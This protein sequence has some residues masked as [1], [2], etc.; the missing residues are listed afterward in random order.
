MATLVMKA[1]EVEAALG[2]MAA[3]L[4]RDPSDGP[5]AVVGIRRGGENLARRLAAHMRT[6]S[7]TE[8]PL[9]MVDITLYRDDG[10]GPHDWPI[11]GPTNIEF[12]MK[13]YTIVLV[14]DVLYTG[15]T[16]RA[17]ID[18]MLDYGRPRA[19]RLAVLVDRGLHELP[20][21]GDAVGLTLETQPT[22]HVDVRVA[23]EPSAEDAVFVGP[24]ADRGGE[25]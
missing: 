17:A 1:A 8:P 13:R 18:A 25:A 12:E 11:I 2:T 22:E 6:H 5:W 4:C 16:V 14:D 7:G 24:A 23:P 9:G 21:R 19:M 15:R 20:I 10:F 3:T